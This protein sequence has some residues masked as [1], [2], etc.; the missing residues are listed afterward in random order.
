[1]MFRYYIIFA[2]GAEN[3]A[4]VFLSLKFFAP[5]PVPEKAGEA[6][7]RDL[8]QGQLGVGIDPDVGAGEAVPDAVGAWVK[9]NRCRK[10]EKTSLPLM[11][12]DAHQV[13]L[14]HWSGGK[15]ARPGGPATEVLLYE[16][17][18]GKH[19]WALR[20]MDSCAAIWEF[21]RRWMY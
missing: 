6:Q 5:D 21:F 14:H 2:A 12:E 20:D 15:A 4:G 16:V 7:R 18:G 3:P 9:K 13:I 10:Y 19:S 17:Q 8:A 1:M 11:R